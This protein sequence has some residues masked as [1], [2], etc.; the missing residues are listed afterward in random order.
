M[1][2]RQA[3]L[4][5]LLTTSFTFGV[6]K[7]DSK[8]ELSINYETIKWQYLKHEA[9][10]ARE[11]KTF[12]K[13]APKRVYPSPQNKRAI[14]LIKKFRKL[15]KKIVRTNQGSQELAASYVAQYSQIES[16]ADSLANVG[17]S[18]EGKGACMKECGDN[19]PGVGGGNGANRIA[20]KLS[21]SVLGE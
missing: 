17:G 21:C 2:I 9:E 13:I 14:A 8:E 15:N 4:I 7:V 12:K 16:Q 6:T 18:A 20:C 10:L 5:T 1:T 11:S 19:F 3:V